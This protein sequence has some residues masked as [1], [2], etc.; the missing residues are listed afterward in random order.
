MLGLLIESPFEQFEVVSLL[1]VRFYCFDVSLTNSSVLILIAVLSLSCL[2]RLVYFEGGLLGG[3]VFQSI[4]ESIYLGILRIGKDSIGV[5]GSVYVGP[6][7]TLFVGILL[8]NLLGMIPYSY[9]ITS[10]IVVTF[11][12]GLGVWLGKLLVG[13]RRHGI[14]LFSLFLPEGLPF[15]LVPF[16]VIIEVVGFVIPVLSLSVRLFA[17]MMSGHVLLKVL[18]GFTWLIGIGSWL[19]SLLQVMPL[20]VLIGLIGLELSV[21]L[22]Q[23]YVFTLLTCIYLSDME[24]GGH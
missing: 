9:C 23:A 14:R 6:L 10:Q 3:G 7:M 19:G 12:M 1:G 5:S 11:C 2:I 22:I 4:L 17:N 24:S 20:V 13:V 21:A 18:F 16:F 15:P 8:L